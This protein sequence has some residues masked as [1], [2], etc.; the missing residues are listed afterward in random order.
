MPNLM[1]NEE[2]PVFFIYFFRKWEQSKI[3][4][5]KWRFVGEGVRRFIQKYLLEV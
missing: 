5:N 4:A 3:V 1:L 2:Q